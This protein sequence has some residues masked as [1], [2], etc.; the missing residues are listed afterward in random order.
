MIAN[1]SAAAALGLVLCGVAAA[2]ALAAQPA[3]RS[4]TRVAEASPVRPVAA[5]ESED[6]AANCSKPRRRLWVEGEGWIVR[7][8]TICR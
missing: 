5:T 2:P 1:I 6:E 4:P 3:D 8:V 7:R